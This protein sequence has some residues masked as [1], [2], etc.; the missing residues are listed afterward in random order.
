MIVKDSPAGFPEFFP[1]ECFGLIF[2]KLTP[3]E[4]AICARV[5]KLWNSFAQMDF[6]WKSLVVRDCSLIPKNPGASWKK[7]YKQYIQESKL[8]KLHYHRRTLIIAWKKTIGVWRQTIPGILDKYTST[9]TDTCHKARITCSLT[10]GSSVDINLVTG[11]ADKTLKVWRKTP[12]EKRFRLLDTIEGHTTYPSVLT[13]NSRLLISGSR[14][15]EIRVWKYT[16]IKSSFEP[17]ETFS[18]HKSAVTA[19]QIDNLRIIRVFF[20][21]SRNGE[22]KLWKKIGSRFQ[23]GQTLEGYHKREI[24]T[25]SYNYSRH[26]LFSGSADKTIRVWKKNVFK[27]Q[28][29]SM[30]SAQGSIVTDILPYQNPEYFLTASQNGKIIKW[31][32]IECPDPSYTAWEKDHTFLPSEGAPILS[33]QPRICRTWCRIQNIFALT[34]SGIVRILYSEHDNKHKPVKSIL[35]VDPNPLPNSEKTMKVETYPCEHY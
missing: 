17:L 35:K 28:C 27:L 34:P 32:K 20:S 9:H 5:C 10:F 14:G 19:L 31:K 8:K 11:S 13:G 25:L 21:G 24:T 12:T 33:L 30:V 22:I 29:I 3:K 2:N 15:G 4:L 7:F 18:A 16:Y 1:N 23:V 26:L 6:L